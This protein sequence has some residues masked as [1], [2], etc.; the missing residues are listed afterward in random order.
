MK[1]IFGKRKLSTKN[2]L[3]LLFVLM[4]IIPYGTTSVYFLFTMQRQMRINQTADMAFD[5]ELFESAVN[6]MMETAERVSYLPLVDNT[7]AAILKKEHRAYDYEYYRDEKTMQNAILHASNLNSSIVSVTFYSLSGDAYC[8]NRIA[9]SRSL[10]R[11]EW[12][13]AALASENRQFTAPVQYTLSGKACIPLVFALYDSQ[14]TEL[15]GFVQIEYDLDALFARAKAGMKSQSGIAAW[16]HGVPLFG[17]GLT[18]EEL[19]ESRYNTQWVESRSTGLTFALYNADPLSG[20]AVMRNIYLYLGMLLAMIV[21]ELFFGWQVVSSVG[22]SIKRLSIALD[23]ANRGVQEEIEVANNPIVGSELTELMHSYNAL[24]ERLTRSKEQ[25]Y[26]LRFAQQ[27]ATIKALE[28]QINPHFLNNTLN[29]IASLIQLG[30]QETSYTVA[31]NLAETMQFCVKGSSMVTLGEDLEQTARYVYIM[32]MRFPERLSVTLDADPSLNDAIVP[33]F[34][35]QP[36]IEN[37]LIY[38]LDSPVEHLHVQVSVC[39]AGD[40]L[41]MTVQDD[42][43]GI[44]A[45]KLREIMERIDRF[46]RTGLDP[47]DPSVSIGIFNVH[48]RVRARYGA[49]GVTID[50]QPGACRVF[51]HV[52]DRSGGSYAESKDLR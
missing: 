52:P 26:A 6:D 33:K 31:L 43:P 45:Q 48:A 7:L 38:G 28:N 10:R 23:D 20:S 4:L 21:M 50:S 13:Q 5:R 47:D 42:G 14:G 44:E 25:E 41:L 15:V 8:L 34:L 17:T 49:G 16:Q 29:L 37:A 51:V 32:Q 27:R 39:R 24:I 30:E 1:S 3:L 2:G 35:L 22:K 40:G 36:L 9:E 46:N 11:D 18:Q 19:A 12:L